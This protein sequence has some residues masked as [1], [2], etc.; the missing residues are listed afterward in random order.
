M[1][2]QII[3]NF[4]VNI[5]KAID[6]R[7]VVGPGQFYTN[8]DNLPYKY[9]GM[10]VWDLNV[11]IPYV[12]TGVTFSTESAS[13][14]SGSGTPNYL[15]KF[16]A[17]GNVI[18]NSSIFDNATNV[19]IGTITPDKKLTVNGDIKSLGAGGFYGI[20]TNITNI[21][22]SNITSGTLQ[23]TRLQNTAQV[24]SILTSN[25]TQPTYTFNMTVDTPPGNSGGSTSPG[26]GGV[27][28]IVTVLNFKNYGGTS[29][30]YSYDGG[31][32][33]QLILENSTNANPLVP[34]SPQLVLDT[35]E[36]RSSA[37]LKAP[38]FL[39][40]N[41]SGSQPSISFQNQ[42][43]MGFYRLGTNIM[44]FSNSA[45]VKILFSSTAML[46]QANYDLQ[47][48]S[49]GNIWI[50]NSGLVS[51]LSLKIGASNTGIFRDTGS[52]N[53][54]SFVTGGKKR[55]Q[56]RTGAATDFEFY[57]LLGGDIAGSSKI[58]LSV[59]D[60]GF[61]VLSCTKS[62]S[63]NNELSITGFD[64]GVNITGSLSV[65]TGVIGSTFDVKQN[66]TSN[67]VARIY[68]D[69]T[70]ASGGGGLYI[71]TNN[72]SASN[73][74]FICQR[75]SGQN[76]FYVRGDNSVWSATAISVSDRTLKEDIVYVDKSLDKLLQLKPATYKLIGSGDRTQRGLIAQDVE[77]VYPELINIGIDDKLGL[78]YTG[79]ISE[80]IN[81]TKEQ[82][83]IIND[84]KSRIESLES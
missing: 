82:Q 56:I 47:V 2:I 69:A 79:L 37:V 14:V 41:G 51:D 33:R 77:E 35:A 5:A 65:G 20:G 28:G 36:I 21:N 64:N 61:T 13:S 49:T 59:Y 22:A 25:T 74:L 63:V 76:V 72:T 40:G 83:E 55:F 18:Q 4:E 53:N 23:L 31:D 84:L 10:R 17:P 62:P 27:A 52:S 70:S 45:L 11:S 7:L 30:I 75:V 78:N 34:T 60:T 50:Q 9:P 38:Y 81:A 39:A 44:A 29:R 19:G 48:S 71:R 57:S 43:N 3:D 12:W 67:Y 73:I 32:G 54:L 8:K 46:L 1:A 68:N 24:G 58:S 80:L 42:S 26:V 6:N 66:T 16:V 15:P